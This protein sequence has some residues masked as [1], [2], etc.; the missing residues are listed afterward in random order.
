[1]KRKHWTVIGYYEDNMQPFVTHVSAK[2]SSDAAKRAG[3]HTDSP[4]DLRIVEVL[5]G[6]HMGCLGNNE[7]L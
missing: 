3:T 1:M 4:D 6:R 2:N 7:V 5:R